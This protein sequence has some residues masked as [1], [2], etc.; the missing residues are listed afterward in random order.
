MLSPNAA[1]KV[2]PMAL[3]GISLGNAWSSKFGKNEDAFSLLDE[4]VSLGGNFIDT[5]NCYCDGESE[6][7]IGQWMEARG[8]RDQ[9]IIAT[10]FSSDFDNSPSIACHSNQAG[11]SAKS[12]HTSLRSSL[13]RLR[14]DYID[15]Y[16]VHW[17]DCATSVEELMTRLHSYVL[18]H[19]VLYLGISDAPAWVVVKA[20]MYARSHGLTPFSVYQGRWNAAYRDMEAEIIPMCQDQGMAIVPWAALGGGQLL[21]SEQRKQANKNPDS[22]RPVFYTQSDDDI[23]VCHAIEKIADA[24]K[25]SFQAVTLAYLYAQSTHVF[26]IVG[27]Q[28]VQHVKEMPDALDINLSDSEIQDIRSA[29]AFKPQFPL[30]FLHSSAEG[31]SEHPTKLTAA[32]NTQYQMWAW[33]DAPKVGG[34]YTSRRTEN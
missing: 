21:S 4:F 28:T 7:L 14:T 18:S 22:S 15:L 6:N 32:H 2:S 23:K 34:G 20:N 26:P 27:V 11:N 9:I 19:N 5:A 17:W 10:K 3:G 25:C 29:K 1:I 12:L 13:K 30:D 8:N 24:R 16:Y 33:I 31:R